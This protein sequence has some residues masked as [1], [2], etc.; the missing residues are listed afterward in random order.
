MLIS[1][2]DWFCCM[3]LVLCAKA[4]SRLKMFSLFLTILFSQKNELSP[5]YL[6]KECIVFLIAN[7]IHMQSLPVDWRPPPPS[8]YSASCTAHFPR[9][10]WLTEHCS[11]GDLSPESTHCY[12]CFAC[13]SGMMALKVALHPDSPFQPS[14]IYWPAAGRCF[15][16]SR[17]GGEE[18]WLHIYPVGKCPQRATS[19]QCHQAVCRRPAATDTGLTM[20]CSGRLQRPSLVMETPVPPCSACQGLPEIIWLI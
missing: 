16:F 9:T 3:Q 6:N 19:K 15:K 14:Y 4:V 8:H 5:V 11:L 18:T 2:L 13:A 20:L 7:V 10:D 1:G 17:A 12:T